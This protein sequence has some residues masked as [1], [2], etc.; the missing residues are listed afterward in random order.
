VAGGVREIAAIP[1]VPAAEVYRP[2][3]RVSR[4]SSVD[5]ESETSVWL[6]SK[7]L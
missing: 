3:L 6:C 7:A 5:R 4:S 2:W 1:A